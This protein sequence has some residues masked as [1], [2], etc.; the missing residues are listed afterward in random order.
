MSVTF[1]STIVTECPACGDRQAYVGIYNVECPSAGCR[2]FS[3]RQWDDVHGLKAKTTKVEIDWARAQYKTAIEEQERLS[4]YE[5]LRSAVKDGNVEFW[6][7]NDKLYCRGWW[8]S[9]GWVY[10][11]WSKWE[12]T[13]IVPP[14]GENVCPWDGSCT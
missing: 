14:L 8:E 4:G 9:A 13:W 3:Q 10:S 7:H 5:A 12:N 6:V 1:I 11:V 2:F